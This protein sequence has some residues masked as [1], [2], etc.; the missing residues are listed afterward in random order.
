MFTKRKAQP[1]ELEKVYD[2]AVLKLN[3]HVPTS[4]EYDKILDRVTRLHKVKQEESAPSV[5]RDT[6]ALIAANLVGIG[7]IITHEHTNVIA[8]KAMSLV[9]KPK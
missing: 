8:T 5:S 7:L 9:L 2:E 6:L 4:D 3:D 1:T